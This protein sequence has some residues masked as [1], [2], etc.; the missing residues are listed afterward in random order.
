MLDNKYVEK[1]IEHRRA[2]IEVFPFY[3]M[4]IISLEQDL[5]KLEDDQFDIE[6]MRERAKGI[7]NDPDFVIAVADSEYLRK[8]LLNW[9]RKEL[10]ECESCLKRLQEYD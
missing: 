8:K 3:R 10:S 6:E 1:S 5:T 9:Y 4:K 7:L 2:E